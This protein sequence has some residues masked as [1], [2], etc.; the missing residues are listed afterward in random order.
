LS[1]F[2]SQ[3][4]FFAGE[5]TYRE[6][7]AAAGAYL[8]GAQSA[9]VTCT[10]VHLLTPEQ[11]PGLHYLYKDTNTDSSGAGRLARGCARP[12]LGHQPCIRTLKQKSQ[13]KKPI[14]QACER[15]R[16][17]VLFLSLDDDDHGTV[18]VLCD[19]INIINCCKPF[20]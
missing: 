15:L 13:K 12:R 19:I 14:S 7:L 1:S 9:C 17:G 8:T 20:S 16:V 5:A 11:L 10:N 4:I 2:F 18:P 6:P 3:K